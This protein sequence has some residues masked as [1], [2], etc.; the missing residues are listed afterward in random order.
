MSYANGNGGWRRKA[1]ALS[2]VAN[3]T[4]CRTGKFRHQSR[5][6]AKRHLKALPAASRPLLREYVCNLCGGWHVGHQ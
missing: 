4:Y 6:S 2:N 3:A 1:I 5:K